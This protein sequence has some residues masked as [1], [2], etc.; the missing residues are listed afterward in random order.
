[1]SAALLIVVPA[2]GGSK[3]L[4]GKNTRLLGGRSLLTHTANAVA[5][6]GVEAS[7]LLTTDRDEIAAEG[8]RLGWE[9]P[10]RRPAALSS[11]HAS[12]VGAVL[13]A[14]DWYGDEH[15]TDPEL[16]MVLQPTSPLRGADCIREALDLLAARPD[17]D[18][19]VTMTALHVPAGHLYAVGADGFVLPLDPGSRQV[20]Y[21]PN[22]ALYLSRVPRLR[23]EQTLY[24]GRILP[25]VLD[26]VR[27]IDIDTESDWQLAEAVLAA[28]LAADVSGPAP[29]TR[30]RA[31]K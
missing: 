14:L 9:A 29:S 6:S 13:H 24:A 2:R 30:G 16:V 21:V 18:S 1:M 17:A 19:V 12:T 3:R 23:A 8:E 26:V 28:G 31:S 4:P 27:S 25:L 20:T 10:F 22:G 7:V 15:G 11:D 5:A